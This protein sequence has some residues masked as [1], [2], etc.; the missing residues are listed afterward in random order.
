MISETVTLSRGASKSIT[1]ISCAHVGQPFFVIKADLI[2][3]MSPSIMTRMESNDPINMI[4]ASSVSVPSSSSGAAIVD[5]GLSSAASSSLSLMDLPAQLDQCV[6]DTFLLGFS[7]AVMHSA[8]RDL[9]T[10]R[11][12]VIGVD[13]IK[14]L[15]TEGYTPEMIESA[16][17][18]KQELMDGF[19]SVEGDVRDLALGYTIVQVATQ[20]DTV[21]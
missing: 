9:T 5:E 12:A 15:I 10:I 17:A 20:Y 8:L 6:K 19:K 4:H 21:R 2:G 11:E 16:I 18:S 7:S 14:Q 13:R 3:T 1:S